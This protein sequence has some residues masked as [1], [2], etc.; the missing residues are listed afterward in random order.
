MTPAELITHLIGF[1]DLYTP[2]T[3]RQKYQW[4]IAAEDVEGA[5]PAANIFAPRRAAEKPICF[6]DER[7][8]SRAAESYP[9]T[10]NAP[11]T[12]GRALVAGELLERNAPTTVISDNMIGTLF[13]Q[14]EIA[15]LCFFY[16]EFG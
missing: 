16:D 9:R 10:G 6:F 15:K 1:D 3:F 12:L 14:G 5:T 2:E 11:A 8:E 7:V 13:A 4:K